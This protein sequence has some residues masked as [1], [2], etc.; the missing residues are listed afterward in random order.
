MSKY[1]MSLDNLNAVEMVVADGRIVRAAA[2]ENSDL[3]W[4]IRG[5]GG[6]FGRDCNR[7]RRNTTLRM[8]STST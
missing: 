1:G 5:G 8:C 6:N 2:S 4:A 3:F 7:S